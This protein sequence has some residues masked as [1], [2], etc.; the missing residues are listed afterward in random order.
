MKLKHTAEPG[1]LPEVHY[2]VFCDGIRVGEEM[3]RDT[4]FALYN[5]LEGQVSVTNQYGAC[6]AY[7]GSN[8]TI[9]E[10]LN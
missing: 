8:L 2:Y 5:A 10:V 6:F 9:D 4:A 7:K 3:D 1:P